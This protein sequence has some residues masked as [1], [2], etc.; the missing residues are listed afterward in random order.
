MISYRDLKFDNASLGNVM[1]LVEV[2]A[3]QEY[4][5]KKPTG[6]VL[7]YRYVVCLPAHRMERLPVKIEGKRLMDDPEDGAVEVKFTGLEVTAYQDDSKMV[8]ITAK[9]TGIAPV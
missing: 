1:L 5:D 8:H 2:K 3:I 6:N 9:A 4:K 7:G